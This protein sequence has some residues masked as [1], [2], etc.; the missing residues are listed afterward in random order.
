VLP[1]R[2]RL[3][4]W[5]SEHISRMVPRLASSALSAGSRLYFDFL[6]KT[7]FD[8]WQSFDGVHVVAKVR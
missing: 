7:Q 8:R 6:H 2:R 1:C 4:S 3:L 5:L